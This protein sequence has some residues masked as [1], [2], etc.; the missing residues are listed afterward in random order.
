MMASTEGWQNALAVLGPLEARIDAALATGDVD[1]AMRLAFRGAREA[2]ALVA[3]ER[4]GSETVGLHS[5][6]V[7]LTP[8][9]LD[10][11]ADGTLAEN[12][13]YVRLTYQR[14]DAA[15][16]QAER[17]IDEWTNRVNSP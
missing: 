1:S 13:A 8:M 11:F 5:V 3:D 15:P 17:L 9:P 16:A 2:I 7:E 10:A 4:R 12:G 14:W 6:Y